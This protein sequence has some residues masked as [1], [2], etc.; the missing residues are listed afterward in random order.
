[1]DLGRL[2]KQAWDLFVKDIGQLIVGMLIAAAIP[3]AAAAGIVGFVVLLTIPGIVSGVE[4][5]AFT[6]LGLLSIA[7]LV[8][9][10]I[11]MFAVMLLVGIPLYAGVILGALRRV[12]EGRVMSYWDAFSGFRSLARVVSTYALAYLVVPLALLVV[13]IV[14]IVLGAILTSVPLIVVGA[15]SAVAAVVALVYLG[16]CWTYALI[17]VLDRP[18]GARQA[19]AESREIVRQTGWWWTFLALFL[20]QMALMVVSIV[21]GLIPLAGAAVSLFTAPFSLTYLVAMYFQ[22]RHEDPL[23]DAALAAGAPAAASAVTPEVSAAAWPEA[24]PQPPEEP[25]ASS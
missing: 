12:R 3:G 23:I 20:L 14:L 18:V 4:A 5:E 24:P 8:V 11:A 13:P 6:G 21:A 25:G 7:A 22:S 10:F 17:V 15:A 2:F 16:V 1:M 9:G 19:L